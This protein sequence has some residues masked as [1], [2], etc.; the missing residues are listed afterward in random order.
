MSIVC[1]A[2]LWQALLARDTMSPAIYD[3]V[4]HEMMIKPAPAI[5]LPPFEYIEL[6]NRSSHAVQLQRCILAVNKRETLLPA[7]VLQPD[8][9]L[10]LSAQAAAFGLPNALSPERFPPLPDDTGL[11]VL[12]NSRRQVIHAVAYTADWYGLPAAAIAGRSLEMQDPSLPCSGKINWTASAS[13]AGGTPGAYNTAAR[14]IMDD[15]RPD[16]YFME[17][18]DS[19]HLLLHVSKTLDSLAAAS[20]AG[21]QVNTAPVAAVSVLPP[22]FNIVNLQLA[23]PAD[24]GTVMLQGIIDCQGKESGLKNSLPFARPQPA[25]PGDVV[26]NEI[27]FDPPAG[28]PEFIELYNRSSH[29]VDVSSL[30]LCARKADGQ[31]GPKKRAATNGRLLMPGQFLAVTTEAGRLCN[32]YRCI[33][34]ENIQTIS[35][36]PVMPATAGGLVLLRA[37]TLVL[38]EITY[39]S[40]FHFP[41]TDQPRGVSLERR[42][43]AGRVNWVSAAASAGYATPGYTNSHPWPETADVMRMVLEPPVFCPDDMPPANCAL[44]QWEL[45]GT[46]WVGNVTVF[47][48]AGV[49]IRYLARNMTLGNKGNLSWDG[50][51]ENKVLLPPGIYIFLIEIFD[52]KGRVKRWKQSLVMARKLN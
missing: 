1:I 40:A 47:N 44:L 16:L 49:P 43:S 48:T 4:I 20:P 33:H 2:L 25:L 17:M 21:Y 11:V 14:P 29:A 37:D 22:L 50:F 9:L 45:P 24:S 51:G 19:L 3:V 35:S 41:L 34:R 31:W 27:L 7:F 26:I 28:V 5:G 10:L 52:L 13:P 46:T 18:P 39:Q 23:I 8:S 38:D 42:D 36:L 6:R 30:A 32:N 12:Y 15:A